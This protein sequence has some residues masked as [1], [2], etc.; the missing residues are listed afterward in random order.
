MLILAQFL[1]RAAFGLAL[2]MVLTSPSKVTSGFYR[3]HC[4]VLLGMSVLAALAVST[5]AGLPSAWLAIIAAATSYAG[6]VACCCCCRRR[7]LGRWSAASGWRCWCLLARC[8]RG[9][10]SRCAGWPD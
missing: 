8:P 2:A 7:L 3:N 10:F 5:A 6:A 1:L 4:Y 9:R